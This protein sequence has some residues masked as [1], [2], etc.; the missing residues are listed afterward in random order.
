MKTR[1]TQNSSMA[2]AIAS[3]IAGMVAFPWSVL[4]S[5]QFRPESRTAVPW[6]VADLVPPVLACVLGISVVLRR[7]RWLREQR[8]A[9]SIAVGLAVVGIVLGCCWL[10]TAFTGVPRGVIP[11]PP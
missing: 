5:D 3:L 1:E 7:R 2:E 10:L 9:G 11:L 8:V 6:L 4:V